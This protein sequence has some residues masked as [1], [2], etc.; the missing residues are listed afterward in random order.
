[1][2]G[3][4]GKSSLKSSNIQSVSLYR[5]KSDRDVHYGANPLA[6]RQGFLPSP[7]TV[8]SGRYRPQWVVE[9]LES[10]IYAGV[11]QS[12]VSRGRVF[13]FLATTSS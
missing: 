6:W 9:T 13:N 7:I 1:M 10:R 3:N 12:R 2:K 11:F 8:H 4:A 5:V